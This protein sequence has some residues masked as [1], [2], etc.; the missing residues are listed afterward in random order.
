ME[1]MTENYCGECDE[2]VH[3]AFDLEQLRVAYRG[4]VRCPNCGHVIPP[5]N[6]CDFD[7]VNQCRDCP[8][9]KMPHSEA[10]T[11]EEFV[12]WHRRNEPDVFEAMLAGDMGEDYGRIAKDLL[13]RT[14]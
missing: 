3:A 2:V 12:D 13:D 9:L 10:I 5:C 7:H 8:Y 11:D 14:R 1:I 6:E 4:S